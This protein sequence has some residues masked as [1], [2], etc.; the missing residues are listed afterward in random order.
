MNT[1]KDNLKSEKNKLSKVA[2][3][4][5]YTAIS[6]DNDANT[7]DGNEKKANT[8]DDIPSL[9]PETKKQN[10]ISRMSHWLGKLKKQNN[11]Q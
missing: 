8:L 11:K 10:L 6:K 9:P 5:K 2:T 3:I 4:I 1:S 7:D